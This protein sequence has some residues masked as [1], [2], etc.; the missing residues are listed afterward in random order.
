M[1]MIEHDGFWHTHF[2]IPC[3]LYPQACNDTAVSHKSIKRCLKNADE[4]E[5]LEDY[6]KLWHDQFGAEL[7]MQRM[8]NVSVEWMDIGGDRS[9]PILQELDELAYQIGENLALADG[10]ELR[11]SHWEADLTEAERL[12][13]QDEDDEAKHVVE[14]IRQKLEKTGKGLQLRGK[15][16]AKSRT[17]S[18]RSPKKVI[19]DNSAKVMPESPTTPAAAYLGPELVAEEPVVPMKDPEEQLCPHGKM[20][21][22]CSKCTPLVLEQSQVDT[23]IVHHP[24]VMTKSS[25]PREALQLREEGGKLMQGAGTSRNSYF[26]VRLS[27]LASLLN[28]CNQ[29]ARRLVIPTCFLFQNHSV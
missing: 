5:T 26:L 7:E 27:H 15:P 16:A 17:K 20:E 3:S 2:S 21:S 23:S 24:V 14:R 19:G 12:Y 10:F 18:A 9:D 22:D 1:N 8:K 28:V 4:H 6:I 25:I 29:L 13:V 11:Y